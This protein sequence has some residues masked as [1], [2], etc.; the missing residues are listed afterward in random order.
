MTNREWLESLSDEELAHTLI[1][2]YNIKYGIC[3]MC[4]YCDQDCDEISL[5]C[6]DGIEEWL[7]A[8]H[9]ETDNG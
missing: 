6:M 5:S 2:I 4:S 7:Q 9:E 3:K 8:E 1:K